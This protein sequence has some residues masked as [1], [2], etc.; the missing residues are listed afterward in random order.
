MSNIDYSFFRKLKI[1][2]NRATTVGSSALRSSCLQAAKQEEKMNK[3]IKTHCFF[4]VN[5]SMF[6]E[7]FQKKRGKMSLH[8][9]LKFL[10]FQL[11]NFMSSMSLMSRMSLMSLRILGAHTPKMK[12]GRILI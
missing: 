8:F 7:C 5:I 4:S 9:P 3:I 11:K 1:S 6:K 2:A 10:I 12:R